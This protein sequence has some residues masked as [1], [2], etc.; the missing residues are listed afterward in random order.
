MLIRLIQQ[1]V[2][3]LS[4]QVPLS[5]DDTYWLNEIKAHTLTLTQD[6]PSS[7]KIET[8]LLSCYAL[9]WQHISDELPRNKLVNWAIVDQIWLDF[10]IV[11][12]N[13]SNKIYLDDSDKILHNIDELPKQLLPQSFISQTIASPQSL[14]DSSRHVLSI[15]ELS[16]I[17]NK[18]GLFSVGNEVYQ[19]VWDYIC[20][21]LVRWQRGVDKAWLFYPLLLE[22]VNAY[23]PQGDNSLF[24]TKLNEL[25]FNIINASDEEVYYFYTLTMNLNSKKIYLFE[26]LADCWVGATCLNEQIIELAK[27]LFEKNP[28]WISTNSLVWPVYQI[29]MVGPYFSLSQLQFLVA[30]LKAGDSLLVQKE[31]KSINEAVLTA[32][33]ITPSIIDQLRVLYQL[34]WHEIIDSEKD[35]FV[36]TPDILH[37]PWVKLAEH[38]AGAGLIDK[39]YYCFLIPTLEQTINLVN[40][41]PLITFPL[42][43]YILSENNQQLIY[44]QHSL[45]H[46]RSKGTFYNCNDLKNICP[47]TAKEKERVSRVMPDSSQY[48]KCTDAKK[49]ITK[50]TVEK[51]KELVLASLFVGGLEFR[52]SYSEQQSLNADLAYA[53]FMHYVTNL[54]ATDFEEY[55]NLCDHTIQFNDSCLTV[56]KVL[57][58][59]LKERDCV[60]TNGKYLLKLVLDYQPETSFLRSSIEMPLLLNDHTLDY[61]VERCGL[62]AQSARL[63]YRDSTIEHEQTLIHLMTI[64]ISLMTHRFRVLLGTGNIIEALGYSNLTTLTGKKIFDAIWELFEGNNLTLAR[65][66]YF[67][68]IETMIEPAIK[69]NGYKAS[70]TRYP[71]TCNWLI[72]IKTGDLFKPENAVYFSLEKI[73]YVLL[74]LWA[75]EKNDLKKSVLNECFDMLFKIEQPVVVSGSACASS[76]YKLYLEVNI[77]LIKFLDNPKN[78][79]IKSDVLKALRSDEPLNLVRLNDISENKE[80]VRLTGPKGISR[81]ISFFATS[82]PFRDTLQLTQPVPPDHQRTMV[83]W[84]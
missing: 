80:L 82:P 45:M 18:Q 41:L 17:R 42:N 5:D 51:L 69:D 52:A 6:N 28:A 12:A 29:M 31:L 54:A 22:L 71:D 58:H 27:L 23:Q 11:I 37:K 16:R 83:T 67:S 68:M 38:L 46:Y 72:S 61:F 26:V 74:M 7:Q 47:L 75:Q 4:Q 30:D 43:A 3:V 32:T 65:S 8:W 49:T 50:Y 59:V 56:K 70:L 14:Q 39:N 40:E 64:L 53:D 20:Q 34:R 76:W 10:A 13:H 57:D 62:R 21:V 63:I 77:T 1:F 2:E 33:E 73:F 55:V 60:A 19:S 24:Q 9:R 48:F 81:F 44:L 35:Y 25:N 36:A 78:E 15:K 79:I 84:A 66:T